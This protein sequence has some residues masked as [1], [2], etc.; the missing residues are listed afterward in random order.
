M[1]L[2]ACIVVAGGLALSG[3][4]RP[5]CEMPAPKEETSATPC[6]CCRARMDAPC[7]GCPSRPPAPAPAPERRPE[8]TTRTQ[9]GLDSRALPSALLEAGPSAVKAPATAPDAF[10]P[11]FRR[12]VFLRVERLLD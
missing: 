5:P 2:A 7:T 10:L 11:H 1:K 12:P 4:V 3:A 6:S 9:V 8:E